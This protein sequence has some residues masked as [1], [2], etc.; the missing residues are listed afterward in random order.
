MHA[1]AR[2]EADALQ[3]GTRG[4][5]S[6]PHTGSAWLLPDPVD[7]TILNTPAL[8]ETLKTVAEVTPLQRIDRVWVFPP[9]FVGEVESGL[10]V[11][12]L[13]EP[14]GAGGDQ[15]EVVTV[16]YE[17]RTGKSPPPPVREGKGRGWA[18][19]A[20][21]PQLI[22]GV[23]RRLGGAEDEPVSESIAGDAARWEALI[24]RLA[25]AAVDPANGE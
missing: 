19:A 17:V 23:V 6:P 22:A 18:P 15:R 8:F 2:C 9:R 13:T 10:V 16:Q 24:E 11:L 25:S 1:R 4:C 7:P 14:D 5:R 21:V 12:A 20:L 3:P